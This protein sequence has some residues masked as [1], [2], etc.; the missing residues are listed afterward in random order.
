MSYKPEIQTAGD[1][2]R[3]SGNALRFATQAEAEAY[4]FDLQCRWTAVSATRV[5]ESPDPVN[6]V[7]DP[8]LGA[9]AIVPQHPDSRYWA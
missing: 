4:A 2:G 3:W 1:P 9:K 7:W 8:I 6:Y 5:I